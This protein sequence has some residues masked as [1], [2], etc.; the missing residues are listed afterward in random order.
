MSQK[1]AAEMGALKQ[2]LQVDDEAFIE[3]DQTGRQTPA[4][5][6]LEVFIDTDGNLD[7]KFISDLLAPNGRLIKT[8]AAARNADGNL[9]TEM[10]SK[11][12]TF[13]VFDMITTVEKSPRVVADLIR[14]GV[15]WFQNH[16]FCVP[17]LHLYQFQS[18]SEAVAEASKFDPGGRVGLKWDPR[19][20]IP[21]YRVPQ[22]TL[23]FPNDA[24]YLLVGCLGGLG[25]SLSLWMEGLGAR[26]FIFLS[27]TADEKPEASSLVKTLR[28]KPGVSVKVIRGDVTNQE[29]VR[30]A[31]AAGEGHLRGVIQAAGV[32]QDSHFS[33]MS[34]QEWDAA[35]RP[36][37]EGTAN[38]H[39]ETLEHP[40]DFFAMTSSSIGI[41]GATTQSAYAAANSY[42]DSMA[43]CR[44]RNGLPATSLSLG[45][46]VGVGHV[47]QEM[48]LEGVLRKRGSY[49]I[50]ESEFLRMMEVAIQSGQ[51]HFVSQTHNEINLDRNIDW[52]LAVTGLDPTKVFNSDE[53][54][55]MA[56][57]ELLKDDPRFR[58]ID[59]ARVQLSPDNSV[60]AS[61]DFLSTSPSGA[62][63]ELLDI[64]RKSTESSSSLDSSAQRRA[65]LVSCILQRI[66]SLT[67]IPTEKLLA[68]SLPR[69]LNELGLD[70]IVGAEFQAWAWRE[71]RVRLDFME[72]FASGKSLAGLVDLIDEKLSP[73]PPAPKD[74]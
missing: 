60:G 23:R 36:K 49:G 53:G 31:V 48:G 67:M 6:S 66:S 8:S 50:S 44:R 69:P 42:L 27:R 64:L 51:G 52:S 14:K 65:A 18:L 4:V 21:I 47:E 57:P 11:G 7:T 56:L 19:C 68:E 71:L 1:P 32:F 35:V 24:V 13:S 46:V 58:H 9:N 12:L 33:T 26:N 74:S 2:Y 54:S 45:M 37:V 5:D 15:G 28:R 61:S 55:I 34:L 73:L 70:S 43:R 25:Q 20:T 22:T 16:Q 59:R 17:K 10:F 41:I 30:R 63:A 29:D 40:L 38:L 72:V 39:K 3:L 62:T